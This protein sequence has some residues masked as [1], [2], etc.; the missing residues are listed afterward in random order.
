MLEL[1]RMAGL[2]TVAEV[3][4][5]L[6]IPPSTLHYQIKNAKT[7][8]PPTTRFGKRLYYSEAEV[9]EIRKI[10]KKEEL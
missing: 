9:E 7:V 4:E 8:R 10:F 3:A 2:V 5:S 6:G 1:R